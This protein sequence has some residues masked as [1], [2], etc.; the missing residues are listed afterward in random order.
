MKKFFL[1]G[2]GTFFFTVLII[3]NYILDTKIAMFNSIL[4]I[5]L[6]LFYL[7]IVLNIEDKSKLED[8]STL[9]DDDE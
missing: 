2:F 8:D 6:Y 4:L 5:A 1:I 7:V 9:N 3:S